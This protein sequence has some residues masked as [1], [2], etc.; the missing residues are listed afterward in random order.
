MAK[1]FNFN[2]LK[3]HY[4]PVTLPDGRI[5]MLRTPTKKIMDKFISLKDTL[6]DEMGGDAIDELYNITAAVMSCNKTGVVLTQQEAEEFF[7]FEDVLSFIRE[8][9][10]FINEVTG[11]KNS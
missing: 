4:M 5:L 8:Y 1:S 7:D 9:T 3:K 10:E 11:G 6:G 2:Q